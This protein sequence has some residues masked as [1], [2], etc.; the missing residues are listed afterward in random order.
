MSN[1]IRGAA[2]T[3]LLSLCLYTINPASAAAE[4]EPK[5]LNIVVPA[6]VATQPTEQECEVNRIAAESAA[7]SAITKHQDLNKAANAVVV[8]GSCLGLLWLAGIDGGFS[9]LSCALLSSWIYSAQKEARASEVIN[10]A[11]KEV[12]NPACLKKNVR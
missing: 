1:A 8:G 3:A 2:L 6:P 4:A 9:T 12:R 5:G 11:Y 7:R 10:Q